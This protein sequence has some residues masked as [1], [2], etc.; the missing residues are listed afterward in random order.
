ML[1]RTCSFNRLVSTG[2]LLET[3]VMKSPLFFLFITSGFIKKGNICI[4]SVD[5]P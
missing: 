1:R 4:T 2:G 3:V 5:F